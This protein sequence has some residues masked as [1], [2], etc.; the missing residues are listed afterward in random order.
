MY[1]IDNVS[2]L[3]LLNLKNNIIILNI[4][5][6]IKIINII[7]NMI[8]FFTVYNGLQVYNSPDRQQLPWQSATV[9]TVIFTNSA[10][11]AELV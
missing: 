7:K 9:L 11:W 3:K 8:F 4:M 1:I 2:I 10:L 5:N 6:I